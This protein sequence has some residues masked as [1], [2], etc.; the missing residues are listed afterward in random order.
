MYFGTFV[1]VLCCSK[2]CV[3]LLGLK[4]LVAIGGTLMVMRSVCW[5]RVLLV[6]LVYCS[7]YICCWQG[8]H[9]GLL[10]IRGG[11]CTSLP[12]DMS[13]SSAFGACLLILLS[14]LVL[15]SLFRE[16][17]P[18]LVIFA[19]SREP[20]P[21]V[22]L[23][24]HACIFWLAGFQLCSTFDLYNYLHFIQKKNYGRSMLLI[25]GK[26]KTFN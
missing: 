10:S 3:R 1:L 12:L 19:C 9:V 6:M 7:L 17:V 8:Q 13:I 15:L 14:L 22:R 2:G 5:L 23:Y 4:K 11:G 20:V 18:F 21:F 16:H 24:V 25:L 26:M